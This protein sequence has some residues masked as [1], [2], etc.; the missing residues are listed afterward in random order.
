MRDLRKLHRQPVGKAER[1][2]RNHSADLD[3]EDN[4]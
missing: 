1:K 2:E 4:K 3:I